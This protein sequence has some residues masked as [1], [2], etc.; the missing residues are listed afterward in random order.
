MSSSDI[1]IRIESLI[2]SDQSP[3]EIKPPLSQLRE[4]LIAQQPVNDLG[5]PLS[6]ALTGFYQTIIDS[7][8]RKFFPTSA[9]KSLPVFISALGGFGRNELNIYS[10]IDI[11]FIY[12]TP[13]F[14]TAAEIKE[15]V[16]GVIK[17]LWDIGLEIGHSVR[18]AGESLE[19][20]RRDIDIRTSL[21][22]M[23]YLCGSKPTFD[24][25][26]LALGSEFS[27]EAFGSF[28]LTRLALMDR[29]HEQF[30]DSEK[31]LE[32]NI[33]EGE[34]GLR[35]IH[36]CFWTARVWLMKENTDINVSENASQSLETI[37][38]LQRMDFLPERYLVPFNESFEFLLKTR[39]LLHGISGR[40]NDI[41]SYPLQAKV[42][43]EM[44]YPDTER[45]G[46]EEFMQTYYRHARVISNLA[47]LIGDKMKSLIRPARHTD[48]GITTVENGFYIIDSNLHY[49]KDIRKAVTDEPQLL[50]EMFLYRQ[51]YGVELSEPLQYTIREHIESVNESF[52]TSKR[53]AKDFLQLWH[54]EGRVASVL[55]LMHD[56]GFLERY[57]PEFG[58]IV[59]H[60]NYNVYHAYTTDE[61]LIVAVKRLESLFYEN[62]QDESV[63]GH[64]REIYAELSLFEK[65]QLYWAVFLH[66]IG[67]SRGG[68]HSEIGVELA[69]Q[70]FERLGYSENAESVYFL[71]LNHLKMEQLAFRRNL[72]DLETIAEF[73]R[74]VGNRRWLRMLYLL[75]FA[76]MA[77]ARKNVWTE[78]KGLLLKELFDK[79]DRYLKAQE[80][81]EEPADLDWEE[82]DYGSIKL[83]GAL[84]LTFT[85]RKNFTEVL[86]V[87]SDR[88]F[89]LSQI[90]G[91]MSVCDIGILEANVYT[92]KDAVIIDQFRV[93]S[94]DSHRPL[95]AGQKQRLENYLRGVLEDRQDIETSMEKLRARWKR[96]KFL[97][98][99]ETEIYF[100]DNRKF[101]IIDIFTGDRIGL[102]YLITHTLSE[103]GLNI[104]S[105]KIGTRLDGA[106]DCFYVLDAQGNKIESISQQEEIRKEIMKKLSY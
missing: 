50:M 89:R 68:D 60:Y 11:G 29:R 93:T 92:R 3:S 37:K 36:N 19:L 95:N 21:I 40:R 59:S 14:D 16:H 83:T 57:L 82:M 100:E 69:R 67:K 63:D 43:A 77:A 7:V 47:S 26:R 98:S 13:Q 101:T 70:I 18:S 42:A 85:D 94:F 86:V 61:H 91:A 66:D 55:E 80:N 38:A 65:Y 31:V 12:D 73:A 10:D 52:R 72:K 1:Q 96:K 39:N 46:V 27:G 2:A 64:L 88:P 20:S 8:Y 71:I 75:T 62:A 44:G 56:L 81:P 102:L 34:G 30:G 99:S 87:T 6:Y 22:E 76:D 51:K 90:C 15:K 49:D 74:L 41:L 35:D 17:F 103:L 5:L 25:F 45:P 28:I 32:P 84:Q 48:H 58:Y 54:Y 53:I 79:T 97:P 4:S 106:A 104:Y 23:R 78:W 9:N 105:A 33:K 24:K